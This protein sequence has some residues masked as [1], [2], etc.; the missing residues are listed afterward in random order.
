M[1]LLFV[2]FLSKV[3]LIFN[4]LSKNGPRR[5]IKIIGLKKVTKKTKKKHQIKSTE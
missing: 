4:S 5:L 3:T 2:I 1:K